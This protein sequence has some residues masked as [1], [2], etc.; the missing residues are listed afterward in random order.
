MRPLPV[1][2]LLLP[3]VLSACRALGGVPARAHDAIGDEM[4]VCGERIHIG[5]TI[6]PWFE[7]PFYSAY[8]TEPRVAAEGPLGLRY[9]PRRATSDPALAAAIERDGTDLAELR[10]IVD[11]FVLHYDACGTSESCF[12]VLQDQRK[13]SV[14]FLLDVDGT[15]YQT[16]DLAEQAWHA[17]QANPRSIGV[18]IAHV[19]A[20]AP[21]TAS[22][23]DLWYVEDAAGLALAIPEHLAAGVR[24]KDFAGRPARPARIRG[25]I[26]GEVL[27]QVDFTP[28]QYESLAKLAAALARTFPKLAVEVPRDAAGRVRADALSDEELGLFRGVIGHWHVTEDKVDPGPAFDWDRFLRDARALAH[29]ATKGLDSARRISSTSRASR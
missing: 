20:F 10:Q 5:T 23:L 11:L 24:T 9:E 3:L 16:L 2:A 17:R 8:G 13:L 29:G 22:P 7:P 12:R 25:R 27:E 15:I 21:G 26:H 19:G 28:E 18:E 6:V 1:R 4:I 14:H